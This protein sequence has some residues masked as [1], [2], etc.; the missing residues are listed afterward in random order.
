MTISRQWLV[1]KRR[2]RRKRKVDL[3]KKSYP[4]Y[5]KKLRIGIRFALVYCSLIKFDG[6]VFRVCCII[7]EHLKACSSL[8][9]PGAACQS[10][11]LGRGGGGAH[12]NPLNLLAFSCNWIF[13]L[14]T[15][16]W[17]GSR[18]PE[19]EIETV[20]DQDEQKRLDY[21][22]TDAERPPT[23]DSGKKKLDFK[24]SSYNVV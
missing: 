18:T 21:G 20:I 13:E 16:I 6:E 14:R 4:K 1:I 19:I 23:V 7:R 8:T 2:K 11:N 9:N 17:F 5:Q 15:F 10:D 22:A 3:R 12:T 24:V